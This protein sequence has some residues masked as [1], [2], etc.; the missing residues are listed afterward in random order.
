MVSSPSCKDRKGGKASGEGGG[1]ERREGGGV[2]GR[3][4]V[5]GRER[6]GGR[7]TAGEG[8]CGSGIKWS[9]YQE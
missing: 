2:E 4:L 1:E 9:N 3:G 5:E 6:E 7:K 8:G